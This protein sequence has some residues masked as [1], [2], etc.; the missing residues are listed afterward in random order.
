MT[1]LSR[2]TALKTSAAV[3]AAVLAAPA[4]AHAAE[5]AG[6][7]S[8]FPLS[9]VRLK[10]SRFLTAQETNQ[11]YLLSLEP[12]RLL[13]NFRAGAGLQP[14]LRQGEAG[15]P[16][17]WFRG[18]SGR[19]QARGADGGARLQSR[20]AR[21]SGHADLFYA[22]CWSGRALVGLEPHSA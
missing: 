16:P 7:L 18:E 20:S 14:H 9:Q 13:H 3:G 4:L 5:T 17:G 6:K 11:R 8:S 21:Q 22:T 19:G 12:D 15:E 2:R 10:P 1:G